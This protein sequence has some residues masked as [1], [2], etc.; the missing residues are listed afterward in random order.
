MLGVRASESVFSGGNG[1]LL[2]IG[3]LAPVENTV[4]SLPASVAP[5]FVFTGAGNFFPTLA[6][7]TGS[8]N[9]SINGVGAY[10]LTQIGSGHL[11]AAIALTDIYLCGTFQPLA[12]NDVVRLNAGT[13]TSVANFSFAPPTSGAYAT[14]IVD[15]DSEILANPGVGVGTVVPEPASFAL[16]A[17]GLLGV[18]VMRSR[19]RV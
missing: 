4:S 18:I 19:R 5:F 7:F 14:L 17:V 2:T 9:Y 13:L 12:M 15:D 16:M 1:G 6:G 10:A 8:I 11:G 3:L